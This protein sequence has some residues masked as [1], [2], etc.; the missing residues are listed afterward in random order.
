MPDGTKD[1]T[2]VRVRRR[3]T[4]RLRL[5]LAA[6]LLVPAAAAAL[7]ISRDVLP[8]WIGWIGPHV[9]ATGTDA[10]ADEEAFLTAVRKSIRSDPGTRPDPFE[11]SSHYYWASGG[12]ARSVAVTAGSW[13]TTM[14]VD[15]TPSACFRRDGFA[16]RVRGG[17]CDDPRCQLLAR[18]PFVETVLRHAE[19]YL[20]PRLPEPTP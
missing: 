19:T 7:S 3:A 17:R 12:E 11:Y 10:P 5:L 4:A 1:S 18:G 13:R 8:R 20:D 2:N 16:P 9:I 6:A 14:C 15:S